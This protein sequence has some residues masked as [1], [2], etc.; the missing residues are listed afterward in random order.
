MYLENEIIGKVGR[1]F[2]R[3]GTYIFYDLKDGIYTVSFKFPAPYTPEI[4]SLVVEIQGEDVIIPD[5]KLN[6]PNERVYKTSF[7]VYGRIV[8]SDGNAMNDVK[9]HYYY[10]NLIPVSDP[11][12]MK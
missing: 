10:K 7:K 12:V 5:V 2:D 9:V 11:I 4:D 8:D 3:P 6:N 1:Y